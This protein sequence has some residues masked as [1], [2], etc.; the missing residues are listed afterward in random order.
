MERTA[1]TRPYPQ[2]API[3]ASLRALCDVQERQV[4]GST[5]YL[6]TPR[7]DASG[8]HV[9]YTHGGA[10]VHPLLRNH[11]DLLEALIRSTGASVTVPL[12]PLAPEHTFEAAYL[13][14]ETVYRDL[15]TRM[16][17]ERVVLCGDSAGGALAL[18]QA[19]R[20]RDAGL[21]QPGRVVLFAP[22]LDLSLSDP[23]IREV[24]PRDVMLRVDTL[25]L[26]GRWWAGNANPQH[27]WLSPLRAD[28]TGLSPIDVFQGTD[29]LFIVDA[30][31]FHRQALEA[32]AD[33]RLYETPG[34]FHV[35]MAVPAIPEAKDVYKQIA[36]NLS[37]SGGVPT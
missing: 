8:W 7:K 9:I 20:Y 24:E 23:R 1:R 13:L 16:P 33:V 27:P 28:L 4:D 5:V 36:R 11:W 32:G 2:P 21:P 3:T 25:C 30:R 15:L 19:I 31:T 6:L 26:V 14:L 34:G 17:A 12:Y 10:Y 18:G 35:F 29:D 37:L 22:W